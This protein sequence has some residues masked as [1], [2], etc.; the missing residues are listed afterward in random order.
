METITEKTR[1][2]KHCGRTMTEENF[3]RNA[4][5]YYDVC[6]ECHITKMNK[7]M[8]QPKID[9]KKMRLND[10]TPRELIEEL[11][12]RGY[13]GTLKYVETHIIDVENF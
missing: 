5:G 6:K 13:T 4:F 1:T 9:P 8:K 3:M 10:F 2:C 7:A 11:R 12:R